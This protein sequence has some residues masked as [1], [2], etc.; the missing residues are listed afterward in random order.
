MKNS[1]FNLFIKNS[2]KQLKKQ[3]PKL[4]KTELMGCTA[5]LWE[6]VKKIKNVDIT[7]MDLSEQ[8]KKLN[9]QK[10]TP[11][12]KNKEKNKTNMKTL[13]IFSKELTIKNAGLMKIGVKGDLQ[14]LSNVYKNKRIKDG[15]EMH[16]LGL[17]WIPYD[18]TNLK[19]RI[20][21]DCHST[22]NI[23]WPNY[24]IIGF[25]KTWSDDGSEGATKGMEKWINTIVFFIGSAKDYDKGVKSIVKLF[26]K[27][28]KNGYCGRFELRMDA[29]L[30]L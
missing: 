15:I 14:I 28:K 9:I 1:I 26:E 12:V 11:V 7:T 18:H 27:Y 25:P 21:V 30:Y 22:K 16:E 19:M 20:I 4:N 23:M 17:Y 10:N 3:N 13:D 6:N 29:N 2:I 5:Q 8:I 24:K